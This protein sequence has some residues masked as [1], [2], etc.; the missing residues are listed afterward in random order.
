MAPVKVSQDLRPVSE[1]KTRTAEV[2]R[3]ATETGR[4]LV[5]TRHGRGVAVL[6]S[7]EVFEE[8]EAAAR[9]A[10]LQTAVE[11]AEAD[12]AAGR[13]IGHPEV[14]ARLEQRARGAR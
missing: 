4:P 13:H 3:Q 9:R 10:D 7:V 8:L 2:L 14:R 5:L 1:L 12:I 6:L 11:V